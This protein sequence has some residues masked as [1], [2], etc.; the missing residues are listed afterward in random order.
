MNMR[1]ERLLVVAAPSCCGKTTFVQRLTAGGPDAREAL[2]PGYAEVPEWKYKDLYMHE[3]EIVA[4]GRQGTT[5][6]M[7]HY[8]LPHPAIRF[9]LRPGYDKRVRR[10]ILAAGGHTT[11]A[12]LLAPRA[13][14]LHRVARRR[15][16]IFERLEL[17]EISQWKARR[18]LATLTH[19]ERI[20]ASGDR[21][22]RIYQRWFE[23]LRGI[24][25]AE[26]YLFDVERE[27]RSVAQDD[28]L[29]VVRAWDRQDRSGSGRN[30]DAMTTA[31]SGAGDLP[32]GR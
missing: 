24:G 25:I 23:Y 12:T 14:L 32:S 21:L 11:V 31:S 15:V 4:L 10:S 30:R 3:A 22:A 17:G 26:Q 27:P 16:R 29:E 13:I 28:W 18:L 2:I 8:T 7:L 5:N 20:Y 9:W 1:F 6:L 19:L